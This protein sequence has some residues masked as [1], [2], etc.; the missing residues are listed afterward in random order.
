MAK[1][2]LQDKKK[3][4]REFRSH[5]P[6]GDPEEINSTTYLLDYKIQTNNVN[7]GHIP[8]ST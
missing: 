4:E 6:T 1:D 3:I 7:V 8:S 2:P 5:L